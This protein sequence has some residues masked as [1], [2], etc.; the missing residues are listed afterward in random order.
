MSGK[1]QL[2]RPSHT[3][4]LMEVAQTTGPGWF[5][6][7]AIPTLIS[8]LVIVGV[9]LASEFSTVAAAIATAPTGTPGVLATLAFALGCNATAR[10]GY[11]M[12][13]SYTLK[14]I[15]GQDPLKAPRRHRDGNAST[16]TIT[17]RGRERETAPAKDG[18][19]HR[20]PQV[21]F[22]LS[23]G[24]STARVIFELFDDVVPKT[25][26]NFRALCLG[27]HK[28]KDGNALHYKGS[29]FHRVIPDF[30]LQGGDITKGDGTGG[31][32]I[33]G[34]SFK[35]ENFAI[36]HST[37]GLLSM[38]NCGS[39]TNNS[40]FFITVKA[41]PWLDG[42]HVVFGRVVEGMDTIMALSRCKTTS[43]DRPT[44]SILVKDCGE[45]LDEEAQKHRELELERKKQEEIDAGK[46]E[47]QKS[48]ERMKQERA[49]IELEA[50]NVCEAVSSAVQEGIK[51]KVVP[52]ANANKR[53]KVGSG[54][55][56]GL[57]DDSSEEE[58]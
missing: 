15:S 30:M 58:D 10:S 45:I 47:M 39:N 2:L 14:R 21:Y 19:Q 23:H 13:P 12:W 40:Q 22:D 51:R 31:E 7:T 33:Y 42:R 57:E 17:A 53:K 36:K 28:G 29:C 24:G 43:G 48:H 8:V 54:M 3:R 16:D 41:T 56:K 26:D 27:N 49:K 34:Y 4:A 9:N 46:T 18:I 5:M 6:T 25:S 35:D 11:G 20:R 38:A 37:K 44:V 32:S 50:K 52:E 55:F 1:M